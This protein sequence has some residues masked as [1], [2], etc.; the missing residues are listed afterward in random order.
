VLA[1]TG[2]AKLLRAHLGTIYTMEGFDEKWDE[3]MGI[4][5]RVLGAGRKNVAIAAA[6][7][8]TSVL[9]V[10]GGGRA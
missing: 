3:L 6:Q 5:G 8:L 1:L 4:S 7:L 9:Q 10:R 2:I